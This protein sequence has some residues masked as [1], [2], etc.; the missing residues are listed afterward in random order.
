MYWKQNYL[1]FQLTISYIQGAHI[2]NVEEPAMLRERKDNKES[3]KKKLSSNATL[4]IFLLFCFAG[5][6][7]AVILIN[8]FT[9]GWVYAVA[10]FAM[11]GIM[12]SG[13]IVL[14][15]SDKGKDEKFPPGYYIPS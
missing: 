3:T 7:V 1:Q 15:L 9:E 4:A 6:L 13:F 8:N 5:T 2:E 12:F 11:A 10:L 14:S